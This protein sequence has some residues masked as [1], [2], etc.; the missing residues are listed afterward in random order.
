V[1]WKYAVYDQLSVYDYMGMFSVSMLLAYL[2]WYFVELPVRASSLWTPRRLFAITA[3]V[4][5]ILVTV[6]TECVFRYGWRG[7]LHRKANEG[8]YFFEPAPPY[9]QQRVF[10]ITRHLFAV[11]GDKVGILKRYDDAH[12]EGST[13]YPYW[14]GDGSFHI[15]SLGNPKVFL[16]GDSHAGAL[17]YG[18]DRMLTANRLA[19]YTVS[20]S[21]SRLFDL[22]TSKTKA[23]LKQLDEMPEVSYVIL[24][25]RW[26]LYSD[27]LGNDENGGTVFEDLQAFA[28]CIKTKGKQLFILTDVPN[29]NYSPV[30]IVARRQIIAPRILNP[31]WQ[32]WKQ[33]EGEY[34]QKQDNV[35]N[36]RLAEICKVT[37]AVF[38]PL[39]LALKENG[40][41]II[42]DKVNGS[43]V[44]LYRNA[45]HLS[46]AGALR[47]AQFIMPYV[48]AS[49]RIRNGAG[50]R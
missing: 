33:S 19:G 40:D 43:T 50:N 2:S 20:S 25:Q 1:F 24:A 49:G 39:H 45:D 3:A 36:R 15:G 26:S 8:T 5:V 7:I 4:G 38:I 29:Y 31:E 44:A 41:Y 17:R 46:Q 11:M 12:R 28:V 35:I 47:A 48:F 10:S 9:I 22:R 21:G 42:F 18:F 27:A 30:D 37:G 14:G 23:A 13:K 34:M 6:G 16:L 32:D